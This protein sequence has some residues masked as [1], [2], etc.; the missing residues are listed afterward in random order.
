MGDPCAGV[1]AKDFA[2]KVLTVTQTSKYHGKAKYTYKI[3]IG[4]EVHQKTSDAGD[5]LIGKH[6][7]YK[8]MTEEF[9]NGAKCD[10][11]PREATVT[12]KFGSELKLL[13]AAET[14]MCKYEYTVQLPK[15]E[16]KK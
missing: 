2:G 6:K 4:G 14:S 11:T 3:T 8:G 12:Y 16:C 15:S 13:E 5:Y 7:S 1:T 10:S 9:K